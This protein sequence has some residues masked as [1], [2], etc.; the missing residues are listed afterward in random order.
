MV[1][2]SDWMSV[3]SLKILWGGFLETSYPILQVLTQK[4]MAKVVG[5]V[6]LMAMKI[7]PQ[8]SQDTSLTGLCS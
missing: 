2:V 3:F 6:K 4:I 8:M 1:S 7:L 5:L